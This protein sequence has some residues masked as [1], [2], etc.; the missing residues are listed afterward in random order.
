MAL[1]LILS[2]HK[3]YYQQIYDYYSNKIIFGEYKYGEQLP[4]FAALE[5]ELAIS[6]TTIR[7][8]YRL[9]S[10]NGFIT[11]SVNGS[12]VKAVDS[13]DKVLANRLTEII[14]VA[15]SYGASKDT[16]ASALELVMDKYV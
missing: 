3:P 16:I 5:E 7:Q 1:Q 15:V 11:L 2:P 9:L 6:A 12:F 8:A 10:E 4:S 13:A 14:D